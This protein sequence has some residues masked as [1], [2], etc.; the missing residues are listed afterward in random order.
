MFVAF[1][2]MKQKE[3]I[4]FP[5]RQLGL[6]RGS[7]SHV[8]GAF[9]P[10]RVKWGSIKLGYIQ[11]VNTQ[12]RASSTD[13]VGT[14]TVAGPTCINAELAVS[15][16]AVTVTIASKPTHFAYPQRDGQAELARVVWSNSKTVYP[17]TVTHLGT[18]PARRS[19]FVDATNDRLFNRHTP[20]SV[21][22]VT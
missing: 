7:S 11:P 22:R 17:R 18:K 19:D 4:R 16:L 10:A 15:S 9:Q 5:H 1:S 8:C 21:T 12:H 3:K 2:A 14:P 6:L 13:Q 20:L